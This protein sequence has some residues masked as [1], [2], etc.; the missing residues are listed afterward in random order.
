MRYVIA[1]NSVATVAAIEAIRKRDDKGEIVVISPEPRTA[2]CR[3]LITYHLAGQVSSDRLSYKQESFYEARGVR[4]LYNKALEGLEPEKGRVVLTGGEKLEYDRL[5]LAIGATPFI[6]PIEGVK[7][8]GVHPFTS[9]D[10]MEAVEAHLKDWK[11]VVVVGAGMIGMKT[12][13]ALHMR[14]V[15]VTIVE[16]LEKILPIVLDDASSA[17]AQ[18]ALEKAGVDY[19]LGDSVV[20]VE[21]DGRGDVKGV[22]LKSGAFIPCQGVIVAVGVRPN[23]APLE[24]SGIDI[25]K[26]VLVDDRMETNLENVFAAGDVVEAY[27]LI[28][29]AKRPIQLW[30]LAYRQ[31]L[32]AGANMAG[33]KKRYVGGFPINSVGFFDFKVASAGLSTVEP[34]VE[35][36]FEVMVFEDKERGIYRKVVVG[37]NRL[38]GF[39]ILNDISRAGVYS[40]LIWSRMDVSLFKD[41]LVEDMSMPEACRLSAHGLEPWSFESMRDFRRMG[42]S[43]FPRSYR[44]HFT[45]MPSRIE[46]VCAFESEVCTI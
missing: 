1:G 43:L 21:R 39:I 33:G 5:L 10:H 35:E 40:G 18:E 12:A 14:G 28:L 25:N 34:G 6:P 44:K 29:G 11:E 20:A 13:E 23:V 30:P 31:G 15:K 26:G 38:M 41:A 2:Y 4:V 7:G 22:T 32:I 37:N 17:W 8:P 42:W 24:G 19:V 36:S 9:I 16:L 45:A 46:E 3:P 27:D